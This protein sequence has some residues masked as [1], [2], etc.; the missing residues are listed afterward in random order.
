MIHAWFTNIRKIINLIYC[1][2]DAFLCFILGNGSQNNFLTINNNLIPIFIHGY[3]EGRT[4]FT[5]VRI[6]P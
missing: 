3:R 2:H 6:L 5:S 1:I 4:P